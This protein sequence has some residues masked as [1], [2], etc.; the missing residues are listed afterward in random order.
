MQ[1]VYLSSRSKRGSAHRGV[2]RDGKRGPEITRKIR[3][4][5]ES[6]RGFEFELS[7]PGNDRRRDPRDETVVDKARRYFHIACQLFSTETRQGLLSLPCSVCKSRGER[8][9][10]LCSTRNN[11]LATTT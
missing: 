10:A 3:P 7:R 4:T 2:D 8:E 5:V 11:L 6:I 9:Y 1:N